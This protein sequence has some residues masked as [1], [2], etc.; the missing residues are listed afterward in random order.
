MENA[1]AIFESLAAMSKGNA[2]ELMTECVKGMKKD[3]GTMRDA[4]YIHGWC[5]A[6]ANLKEGMDKFNVAPDLKTLQLL[7]TMY[8]TMLA[9]EAEMEN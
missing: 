3:L 6:L 8:A 9:I 4:S 2:K 1:T 7:G 5:D